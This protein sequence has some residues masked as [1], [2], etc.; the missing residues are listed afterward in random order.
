[1]FTFRIYNKTKSNNFENLDLLLICTAN[2]LSDSDFR[3]KF[4]M[5]ML[6][7]REHNKRDKTDTYKTNEI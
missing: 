7:G 5:G 6:I 3:K 4:I 2:D 1:M